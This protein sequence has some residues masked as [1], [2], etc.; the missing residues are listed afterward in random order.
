MQLDT[1]QRN[2]HRTRVAENPW[3][4]RTQNTWG[5]LNNTIEQADKQIV[6]WP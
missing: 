5:C 3:E 4:Y 1:I 6:V 2:E